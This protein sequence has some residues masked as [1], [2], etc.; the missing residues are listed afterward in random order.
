[1]S[2]V[3]VDLER[4]KTF[5][6]SL[7]QT[8]KGI[9][10]VNTVLMNQ[11]NQLQNDLKDKHFLQVFSV[12]KHVCDDLTK[13]NSSLSDAVSS[14]DEFIKIVDKYENTNLTGGGEGSSESSSGTSASSSDPHSNFISGLQTMNNN[15]VTDNPSENTNNT[16]TNSQD[17]D[18][19]PPVIER[20]YGPRQ[21]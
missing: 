6:R 19:E 4:L 7:G 9:N 16:N 5:R 14:L 15:D 8:I 10:S 3:N 21:R 17:N 12:V 20:G 11:T 2:E 18:H 13:F 1:M